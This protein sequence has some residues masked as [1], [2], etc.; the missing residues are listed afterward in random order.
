MEPHA[1][2]IVTPDLQKVGGLA[3]AQRIADFA[4]LHSMPQAP[5]NISSPIG[6]LTAVHFCAAI[7]NFLALEVHASDVP[8][9]NERVEGLP[10]PMIQKGFVSVPEKP[11]LGVILNEKVARRYARKDSPFLRDGK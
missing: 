1:R 5:H 3:I 11:G 8:F 10:S 4:D 9:W 6:T 7:P 2:D